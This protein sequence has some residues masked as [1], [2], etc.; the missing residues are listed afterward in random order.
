MKGFSPKRLTPPQDSSLPSL[1]SAP[2]AAGLG[3]G[4]SPRS[5]TDTAIASAGGLPPEGTYRGTTTD[6][7]EHVK[8]N[9][10][11]LLIISI[12]GHRTGVKTA[13]IF[14]RSPNATT[15]QTYEIADVMVIGASSPMSI[16]MEG[17][18]RARAYVE[19]SGKTDILEDWNACMDAMKGLDV[20][21]EVKHVRINGDLRPKVVAVRPAA[22]L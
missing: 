15:K 16:V 2:T 1:A 14:D 9:G 4:R 11:E 3:S 8:P 21:V 12:E 5:L 19:I 20:E 17:L 10:I 7:K 22:G 18:S 13:S 6:V